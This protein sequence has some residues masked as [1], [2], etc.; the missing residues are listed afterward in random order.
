MHRCEDCGNVDG[1]FVIDFREEVYGSVV[2]HRDEHGSWEC[3]WDTRKDEDGK[4]EYGEFGI[5]QCAVCGSNNIMEFQLANID[6]V[7]KTPAIP[8]HEG[9]GPHGN[10]AA[11]ASRR[12]WMTAA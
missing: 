1:A 9:A 8:K 3:Y 2:A 10:A 6:S 12:C 4:V 7:V 5:P 11:Q